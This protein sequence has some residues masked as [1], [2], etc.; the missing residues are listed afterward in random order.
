MKLVHM[1]DLHY[2]H[3]LNANFSKNLPSGDILCLTGD[4]I[5]SGKPVEWQLFYDFVQKQSKNYKWILY[6]Q[7]NHDYGFS[8]HRRLIP[9]FKD[10]SNDIFE[11]DGVKFAGFASQDKFRHAPCFEINLQEATERFVNFTEE[12]D[13]LL[14]HF[15]SHKVLDTFVDRYSKEVVSGGCIAYHQLYEMN[16]KVHLHGHIHECYGID[17]VENTTV[18]NGAQVCELY[19]RQS[20]N[21]PHEIEI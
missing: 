20:K 5:T 14:T 1:S 15:P 10:I 3:N 18:Y 7:G 6:V 13:V 4:V 8:E 12:C 16:P 17:K 2:G 21:K 9:N 11:V 19:V